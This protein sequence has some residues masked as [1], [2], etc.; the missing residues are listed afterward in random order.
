MLSKLPDEVVEDLNF[1]FVS[2]TH[3]K[4][5]EFRDFII[6]ESNE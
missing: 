4:L 2:M 6:I 1:E 5:K 3:E